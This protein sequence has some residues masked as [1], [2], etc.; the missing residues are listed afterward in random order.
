MFE[1][2]SLPKDAN[3]TLL[4]EQDI[5]LIQSLRSVYLINVAKTDLSLGDL[6]LLTWLNETRVLWI[7][8]TKLDDSAVPILMRF[9]RLERLEIQDVPFS[10]GTINS[11][12]QEMP[13]T[14][15]ETLYMNM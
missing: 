9:N 1:G 14:Q 3:D 11:L 12:R 5:S 15:I 13:S 4:M 10:T 6:K 8:N 7:A 2:E